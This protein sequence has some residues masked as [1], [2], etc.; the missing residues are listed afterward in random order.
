MLSKTKT[1][2][3]TPILVG[4]YG[5]GKTTKAIELM[6]NR[7]YVRYQAN[8]IDIEDVYSYILDIGYKAFCEILDYSQETLCWNVP[9][10]ME[11]D[12][13]VIEILSLLTVP[14]LVRFLDPSIT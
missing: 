10:D 8:D 12:D 2:E 14:I 9:K 1:K 13:D 4:G 5:S 11:L 6:G 7:P 3:K